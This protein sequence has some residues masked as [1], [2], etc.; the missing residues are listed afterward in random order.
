MARNP[1]LTAAV[2]FLATFVPL[3]EA[4]TTPATVVAPAAPAPVNSAA[5]SSEVTGAEGPGEAKR[6]ELNVALEK[7]PLANPYRRLF[8]TA[9]EAEV[10]RVDKLPE[11]PIAPALL[12][13]ANAAASGGGM[14][15]IARPEEMTMERNMKFAQELGVLSRLVTQIGRSTVVAAEKLGPDEAAD[16]YQAVLRLG[17]DYRSSGVMMPV[18]TGMGVERGVE[19]ALALRADKLPEAVRAR[20]CAALAALPAPPEATAVVEGELKHFMLPMLEKIVHGFWAWY[21]EEYPTEA[22]VAPESIAGADLRLSALVDF[23]GGERRVSLEDTKRG[24]TF[25]LEPGKVVEGVELVSIDFEKRRA[26]LRVSG[27]ECVL[28]LESKRV[29]ESSPEAEFFRQETGGGR[30]ESLDA[31]ARAALEDAARRIKAAGSPAKFWEEQRA[32]MLAAVGTMAER[33]ANLKDTPP[34]FAKEA[35]LQEALAQMVDGQ[36]GF[37][38]NA[39]ADRI[40]ERLVRMRLCGGALPTEPTAIEGIPGTVQ[41]VTSDNGAQVLR[42]DYELRG[43]PLELVLVAAPRK[44]AARK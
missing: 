43:K 24:V 13:A 28:D 5:A 27:R 15:W 9:I 23:G 6:R 33:A 31:K 16:Y 18:L 32:A 36:W 3:L 26:S 22:G 34:D 41:V 37:L 25:T 2:V 20:L 40:R 12:E 38:R 30:L 4:Q 42:S 29:R 8:E 14:E 10:A 19:Q 11:V 35:G 7:V 1:G 17:R 44:P 39:Y 21:C